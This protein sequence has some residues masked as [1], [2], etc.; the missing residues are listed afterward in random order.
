MLNSFTDSKNQKGTIGSKV[1]HWMTFGKPNAEVKGVIRIYK[2]G[3]AGTMLL[4]EGDRT[5]VPAKSYTI[6]NKF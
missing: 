5:T 4:L 1:C 6:I 2:R 3:K